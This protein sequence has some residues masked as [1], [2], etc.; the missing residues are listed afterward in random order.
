MRLK[1]KENENFEI[2]VNSKKNKIILTKGFV[3]IT[4][5]THHGSDKINPDILKDNYII[6]ENVSIG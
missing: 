5:G 4:S 1:N 3:I 2:T 6:P